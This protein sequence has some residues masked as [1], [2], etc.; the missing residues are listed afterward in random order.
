MPPRRPL[1][2]PFS[3]RPSL[4]AALSP[5]LSHLPSHSVLSQAEGHILANFYICFAIFVCAPVIQYLLIHHLA[6]GLEGAAIAFSIY[7]CLYLVLMAPYM[8]YADLGHVFVPRI[9]ALSPAGMWSHLALALPGLA[10]QVRRS[11]SFNPDDGDEVEGR[12]L[13]PIRTM[14]TTRLSGE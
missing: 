3:S 14:G 5:A 12:V 8:L 10:C 6:W 7:N 11:T 13:R 2:Y 9:E 4:I 1:A